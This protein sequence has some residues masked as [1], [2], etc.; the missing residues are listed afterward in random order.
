MK[1][2]TWNINSLRVRLPHVLRWLESQRPDVLALQE[3]KLP[4][5]DFPAE[6]FTRLGYHAAFSGQP[7]YNG[8]A[9]LAR[10]PLTVEATAL[11]DFDDAQKRVLFAH[12]DEVHILNLYVPNGQSL[13]SDKYQY[14]LRWLEQLNRWLTQLL[15]EHPQLVVLGDLN[16]APEDRDVH[17]PKAWEGGVLVS[18]AERAAFRSLL[19]QGLQDSFR[20]FHQEGGHYSWW[21]YRA[22]AFRR[23]PRLRIDHILL[24]PALARRC[25][26][27]YMDR[28]PR[29]W[30]RPS[31][32][33][34][35][36]TML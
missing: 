8:V 14:K 33:V 23:N 35:V 26:G 9:L 27:T 6:E 4:D 29:G 28:E 11:P 19:E 17:D 36:I 32:H 24:S 7:A 2:A 25:L 22:A 12:L 31:D 18:S 20:L 3:T 15:R 34:P 13:D 16:I 5:P 10:A 21:D 30:E 1:I